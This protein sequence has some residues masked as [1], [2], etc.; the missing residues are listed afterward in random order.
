LRSRTDCHITDP[1]LH[2]PHKFNSVKLWDGCFF[3]NDPRKEMIAFWLR[4]VEALAVG[5]AEEREDART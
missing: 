3:R 2:V 5:I 1:T 4:L